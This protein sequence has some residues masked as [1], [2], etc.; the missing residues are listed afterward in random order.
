MTRI[1]KQI[2]VLIRI[3]CV[4]LWFVL[5][6]SAQIPEILKIDPPSWWAGS[7]VNPVRL[8]IRGRY[9]HRAAVHI[10]GEGIQV[11]DQPSINERGTYMFVDVFIDP[12]ARP[13][14]R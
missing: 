4:H 14:P 6:V 3:F 12:N 7:S 2:S 1:K 10:D 11:L 5:V 9:L 8:M 13:G